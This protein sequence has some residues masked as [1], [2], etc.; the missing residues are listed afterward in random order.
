[1]RISART[2][3]AVR[4]LVELAAAETRPLTCEG[5]A[6]SQGFPSASSRPSSATCGWPAWSAASAAARAATGLAA[7]P[8]TSR[9]P[10]SSGRLTA[11]W[12]P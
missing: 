8:P 2:D 11:F 9:S 5:I 7:R 4:V 6:Q 1:M 12:S 3:Y 10:T